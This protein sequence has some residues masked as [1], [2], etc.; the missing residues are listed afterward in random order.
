MHYSMHYTGVARAVPSVDADAILRRVN[1]RAVSP[2]AASRSTKFRPASAPERAA[3]SSAADAKAE[4]KNL[5]TAQN[6]VRERF[7]MGVRP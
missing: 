3:A 2:T 4:L 7:G 6:L 5:R 1:G